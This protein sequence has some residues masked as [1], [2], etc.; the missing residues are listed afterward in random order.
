ML[1]LEIVDIFPRLLELE[2]EWTCFIDTIPGITPFQLPCWLLTWWTHFGSGKLE[3]LVFRYEGML[4]G[5]IPCFRHDWAG[6]RQ[7]TLI[8]SGISDYLEPPLGPAYSAEI[9]NRLRT[10]LETDSAWD[11]CNW[12]DLSAGS[13][14]GQLT[15][16]IGFQVGMCEDM[17]CTEIPTKRSFDQFWR[18]RSNSLRQ[19]LQRYQHKAQQIGKV[20]FRVTDRA[21]PELIDS[22]ISLHT[23]RWEVR[24]ES[25]MIVANRSAQFLRDVARIFERNRMV[26][27]FSVSFQNR[28]VAIILSFRY[29][30]TVFGYLSGFDPEFK[31]LGFG[32]TILYHAIRHCFEE[33]FHAWNFLRGNEPYKFWWGAEKIPKSRVIIRRTTE[34][35]T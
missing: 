22:L 18:E 15:S 6:L 29:R 19:N 4:A 25:G 2:N 16:K 20:D 28:I 27:L 35:H 8:G 3:V 33:G 17:E 13:I 21:D 11:I 26:R 34:P 1:T 30:N 7:I 24:G 31:K 23:V 14:L 10:Y 5:I 12:Q 9:L 32:R